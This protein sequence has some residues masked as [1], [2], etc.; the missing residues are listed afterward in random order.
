MMKTLHSFIDRSGL[1]TF[2]WGRRV[3]ILLETILLVG[4]ATP[5][6]TGWRSLLAQ[7]LVGA[8]RLHQAENGREKTSIMSR[9][10]EQGLIAEPMLIFS[11]RQRIAVL[12]KREAI[13]T[14]VWPVIVPI[15]AAAET[16]AWTLALAIGI[17]A[18]VVRVWFDKR[19]MPAWRKSRLEW[20]TRDDIARV[21]GTAEL[22]DEFRREFKDQ[23]V[24]HVSTRS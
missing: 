15:V 19:A 3:R 23:Q 1:P 21:V 17:V 6:V 4:C 2:V 16:N 7:V 14:W 18:T 9:P 5:V 24:N 12:D 22:A 13:I 11:K 8:L 20:R 10:K